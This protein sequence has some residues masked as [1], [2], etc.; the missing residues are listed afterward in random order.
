MCVRVCIDNQIFSSYY[1]SLITISP[2]YEVSFEDHM[3]DIFTVKN[4][5]YISYYF[6]YPFHYIYI[7]IYILY[8][9]IYI[10][11]YIKHVKL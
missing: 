6:Y 3:N 11:I 10:Y 1:M 4:Y 9:Y 2:F 7:Y 5:F 8:I